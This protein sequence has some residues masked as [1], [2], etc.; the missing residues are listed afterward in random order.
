MVFSPSVGA[1]PDNAGLAVRRA[2]LSGAEGAKLFPRLVRFAR[3]CGVREADAED[4][5]Q[6]A[7]LKFWSGDREWDAER[8]PDVRK[9]LMGTVS[10]IASNERQ[11]AQRGRES[12]TGEVEEAPDVSH[13]AKA[14]DARRRERAETALARLKADLV[15]DPIA[16]EVVGQVELGFTKPSEQATRLRRSRNEIYDANDR[17]QRHVER[18]A[19]A[20]PPVG[21]ADD[22]EA[23]DEDEEDEVAE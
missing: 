16:L 1:P 12:A 7:L 6:T 17:I 5:A 2:A 11:S 21:D 20:L 15:D 10:S 4:I 13:A 19:K 23:D 14:I 3:I 18:I 9:F 8:Y 22:D